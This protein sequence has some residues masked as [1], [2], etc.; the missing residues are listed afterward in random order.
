MMNEEEKFQVL[1]TKVRP[2]F[3]E[4]F[5]AICKRKGILPYNAIQMMVDAFVR[6]TDDRHNLSKEM[7]QLMAVFEHANGWKDAFNLADPTPERFIESAIYIMS[8]K[9]RK[10]VRGVMVNRPYFGDWQETSNMQSIIERVLEVLS[11]ERYRRLRAL[12]VDMDCAS[13]LELIDVLIDAH[14]VEELNKQY[15]DGFIDNRRHEYGKPV[16]YGQRTKRKHRKSVDD[17]Q[18]HITFT[19]DDATT[20]DTPA[21]EPP[22]KPFGG[23]W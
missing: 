6:Y 16:E 3:Y 2:E 5:N 9:H 10:G 1:A 13:I 12:A 8:G 18:T 22:V 4:T 23:E 14:T 21:D 15:R 17:M 20:T 11:P 19:D 7:E